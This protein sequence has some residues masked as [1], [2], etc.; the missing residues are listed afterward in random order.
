M[1]R[2]SPR[3][4]ACGSRSG[5]EREHLHGRRHEVPRHDS[6]GVADDSAGNRTALVYVDLPPDER[7]RP[8]MFARG[9]IEIGASAGFTVP[10][11]SIVSADGYSY[12]F[13]LDDD[14]T[15]ARQRIE[16]G[17]LQE[18]A[19]EIIGGLEGGERI[20]VK[21]AGFLKDGDRVAVSS[22]VSGS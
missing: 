21:G 10:L 1:A 11:E 6:R 20:V 4:A 2:R 15:V 17:A 7:L 19:M 13:V 9:E 3:D 14:N 8:G 18:G 16:T 5:P 22:G 12:V